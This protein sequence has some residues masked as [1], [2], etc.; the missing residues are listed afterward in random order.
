[1][2]ARSRRVVAAEAAEQAVLATK[3]REML[4]RP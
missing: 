4:D 2:A 1:M 3:I